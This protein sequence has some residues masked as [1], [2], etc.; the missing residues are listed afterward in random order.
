MVV[1]GYGQGGP[2]TRTVSQDHSDRRS[3]G[4]WITCTAA[5]PAC[6]QPRAQRLGKIP[7]IA[8]VIVRRRRC[9]IGSRGVARVGH[10]SVRAHGDL[11]KRVG[12]QALCADWIGLTSIG[13]S[14]TDS[15]DEREDGDEQRPH[16]HDGE[17]LVSVQLRSA[18]GRARSTFVTRRD[19]V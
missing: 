4:V 13:I 19:P 5:R 8:G 2:V 10:A 1:D 6:D 17:E 7:A 18:C 12:E 16:D 3:C 11:P 15:R 14:N 9:S